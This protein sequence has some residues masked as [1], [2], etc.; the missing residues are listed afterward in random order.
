MKNEYDL[1]MVELESYYKELITLFEYK[2]Y[3]IEKFVMENDCANSDINLIDYL[4]TKK[5]IE[6][7]K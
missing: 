4:L 2:R 3:L 6:M 1:N 5:L 7:M